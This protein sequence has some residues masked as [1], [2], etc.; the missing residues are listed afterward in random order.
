[1]FKSSHGSPSSLQV[2][3]HPFTRQIDIVYVYPSLQQHTSNLQKIE[4]DYYSGRVQLSEFLDACHLHLTGRF[5]HAQNDFIA[6]AEGHPGV[7]DI[8]CI[9]HRG[10]LT[11]LLTK[12]TYQQLGLVGEKAS[13]KSEIYHVQVDLHDRTS[14]VYTRAKERIRLWDEQ[15]KAQGVPPWSVHVHGS[16]P[17]LQAKLRPVK[18]QARVRTLDNIFIPVLDEKKSEFARARSNHE[19]QEGDADA[20]EENERIEEL[21]E[22]VGMA[23]MDSER[24]KANDRPNP[25]VAQYEAPEPNRIGSVTHV[26]WS[27]FLP[28]SFVKQVLESVVESIKPASNNLEATSTSPPSS[29]SF[30]SI[31]ANLHRNAPISYI[32]PRAFGEG[33]KTEARMGRW[34]RNVECWSLILKSVLGPAGEGAGGEG[35]ECEWVL[36]CAES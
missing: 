25:F 5:D 8:W 2:S 17:S 6:L 19:G 3:S 10:L 13:K 32:S 14:S 29:P 23:C 16:L 15:R 26:R 33:V 22:W 11:L 21:F 35:E 24:L 30:L 34:D 36:A 20:D 1:M 7:E 18:A 4:C 9:D 28:P 12:Q 31:T 27:G